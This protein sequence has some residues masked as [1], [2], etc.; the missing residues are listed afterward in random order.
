MSEFVSLTCYN[1]KCSLKEGPS[2][3][4]QSPELTQQLQLAGEA[5]YIYQALPHPEGV[6]RQNKG[7][8]LSS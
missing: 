8:D 2:P 5:T 7:K 1:S 4:L 6:R 3:F